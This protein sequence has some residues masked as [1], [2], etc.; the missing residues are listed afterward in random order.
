MKTYMQDYSEKYS[1][2]Y[3]IITK[4][5]DYCLEVSKIEKLLTS[6]GVHKLDSITALSV[7][8]GTGTHETLL[9]ER[10]IGLK[11]DAVDIAPGMIRIAKHKIAS[12]GLEGLN[13]DCVNIKD[14]SNNIFYDIH[15][16]LFNVVNCLSNTSQLQDFFAQVA[17]RLVIDGYFIFEA[18]NASQCIKNPPIVVEREYSDEAAG[19]KLRRVAIPHIKSKKLCINYLVD[20]VFDR[21]PFHLES[22]HNIN[23]FSHSSIKHALERAGLVIVREMSALPDLME[24]DFNDA[25]MSAYVAR[26]CS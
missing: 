1:Q 4:H 17:R 22:V 9:V 24:I 5:K 3:D 10:N 19:Y 25:R 26:R 15:F 7:G 21:K 2:I 13:F 18:W 8:C 6:L 12:R 16:S 11:L 23:L 20:G 14:L